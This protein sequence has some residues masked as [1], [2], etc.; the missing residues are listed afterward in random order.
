MLFNDET[1]LPL[2]SDSMGCLVWDV[3]SALPI[4]AKRHCHESVVAPKRPKL[5]QICLS[6]TG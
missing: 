6:K 4:P 2:Q 3:R 1:I 5:G